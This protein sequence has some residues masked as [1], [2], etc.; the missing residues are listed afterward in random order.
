[1]EVTAKNRS[2]AFFMRTLFQVGGTTGRMADGMSGH[3]QPTQN[4][5]RLIL[6]SEA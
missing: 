5:A 2:R 4:P 3:K 1:M 6:L